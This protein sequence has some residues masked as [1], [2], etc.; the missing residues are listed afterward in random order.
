MLKYFLGDLRS[1]QSVAKL[2]VLFNINFQNL[3]QIA[4]AFNDG[5]ML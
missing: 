1:R 4:I 2:R 3:R 5:L